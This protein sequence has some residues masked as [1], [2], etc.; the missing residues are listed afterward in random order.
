MAGKAGRR[1]LWGLWGVCLVVAVWF[2]GWVAWAVF[3]YLTEDVAEDDPF[4][5][6]STISCSQ[7][8]EYAHGTLPAKATDRRCT[9]TDWMDDQAAGTFRMPRKDVRDWLERSYPGQP[10]QSGGKCYDDAVDLCL[11]I[12]YLQEDGKGP[13]KPSA[14]GADMVDIEVSYEDGRTALVDLTAS[15]M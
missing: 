10:L 6:T 11:N 9:F 14:E 7:A 5:A 12:D 1:V 8:M 3:A 4:R 13:E 15:S 2:V